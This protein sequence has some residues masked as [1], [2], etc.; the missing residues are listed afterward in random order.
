MTNE[1]VSALIKAG[2]AAVLGAAVGWGATAL[3]LT[4]RVEA[5]E[6]GQARMESQ[7]QA[8]MDKLI[9]MSGKGDK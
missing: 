7:Q 2:G 5:I 3:T 9:Q 8:I 4:G 6:K 1:T